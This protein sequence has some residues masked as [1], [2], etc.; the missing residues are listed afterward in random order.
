MAYLREDIFDGNIPPEGVLT[1]GDV[2][3]AF[4]VSRSTVRAAIAAL[5]T[6]GIL[7][8]TP[9]K[10]AQVVRLT[11]KDVRDLYRVRI[12]IELEA[13]RITVLKRF[14]YP[15][16][17][18]AL[19][20]AIDLERS[21]GRRPSDAI[22]ANMRFHEVLIGDVDNEPLA[23]CFNAL[24]SGVK[25]ALAQSGHVL[26]VTK[27]GQEHRNLLMVLEHYR[28]RARQCADEAGVDELRAENV[29]EDV[30]WPACKEMRDHLKDN[31]RAICG[32]I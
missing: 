26:D 6:E 25:L 7:R 32:A 29:D 1:E 10:P 24:E 11:K 3:A 2:A 16:P 20:A 18:E 17:T 31:E 21:P 23:R 30:W 5:V 8:Q 9:N 14:R 19:E 27:L 28:S 15:L 12:P 22:H 13:V 4:S